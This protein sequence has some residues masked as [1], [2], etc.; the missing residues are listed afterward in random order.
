MFTAL[1]RFTIAN[2]MADQVKEAF[3]RRPQLVDEVAGFVRLDVLSPQDVPEEIWLLTYWKDEASFH[4]WHR[5]H[6]RRESHRGIPRGLKLV[7]KS[8]ELCFF[9]HIAS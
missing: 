8:V 6:Q 2:G 7:P 9:E 5:S 4:T 3:R 1:S